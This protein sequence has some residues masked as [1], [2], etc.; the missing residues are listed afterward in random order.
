MIREF[1]RM[2]R[3]FFRKEKNAKNHFKVSKIWSVSVQKVFDAMSDC[4]C[5]HPDEDDSDLCE[6]ADGDDIEEGLSQ[7]TFEDGAGDGFC[8]GEDNLPHMTPHGM[9]FVTR[10]AA[11]DVG[12]GQWSVPSRSSSSHGFRKGEQGRAKAPLGF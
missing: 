2:S 6:E 9:S 12:R 8:T 4:Q 11:A 7:V 1:C 10:C 3:N 5:L